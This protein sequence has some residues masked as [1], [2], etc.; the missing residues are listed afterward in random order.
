MHGLKNISICVSQEHIKPIAFCEK[1]FKDHKDHRK[2]VVNMSTV[3]VDQMDY[4][5]DKLKKMRTDFGVQNNISFSDSLK[6]IQ[7][8]TMIGRIKDY[9][10]DLFDKKMAMIKEQYN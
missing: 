9:S 3:A 5:E 4:F 10:A 7:G 2:E 1:C 8:S 6:Q